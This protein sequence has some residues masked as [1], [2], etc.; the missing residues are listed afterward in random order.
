MVLKIVTV[1]IGA[2]NLWISEK[3]LCDAGYTHVGKL[4]IKM[5]NLPTLYTAISRG[6]VL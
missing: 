3:T 1:V 2:V 6:A 4:C 5:I